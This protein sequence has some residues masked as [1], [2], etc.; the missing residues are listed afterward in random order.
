MIKICDD[1]LVGPLGLIFE[2]SLVTG[3]CSSNWKKAKVIPVHKKESRQYKKNYR[4]ISLLPVFG[5][6]YDKLIFDAIYIH[7]CQNNLIA[8]NQSGFRLGDSTINQLLLITNK[9]YSSFDET[10]PRE[11]GAVFFDLSKAFDRI[12]HDG[13]LYRTLWNIWRSC[14]HLEL[15]I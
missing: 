3:N 11:T 10:P 1:S 14:S 8:S 15:P 12:W 13:L 6:I 7:I 9:I 5:K 2:K 4:P